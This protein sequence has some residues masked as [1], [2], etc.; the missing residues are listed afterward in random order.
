MTKEHYLNKRR[1]QELL[2]LVAFEITATFLA[3]KDILTAS[4]FQHGNRTL[5][6][7]VA[8][9]QPIGPWLYFTFGQKS[10]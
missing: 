3:Y 2:P 10:E 5:W 4:S 7:L 9:I 1:Q 8:L 6:L